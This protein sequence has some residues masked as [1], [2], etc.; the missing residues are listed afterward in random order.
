MEQLQRL[1]EAVIIKNKRINDLEHFI[2][3]ISD[4]AF[5]NPLSLSPSLQMEI[6]QGALLENYSSNAYS[7]SLEGFNI[8]K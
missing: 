1:K 2:K 6:N 5:T 8:N 4:M 7:E 3:K